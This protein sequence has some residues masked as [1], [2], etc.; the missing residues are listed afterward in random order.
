MINR[1]TLRGLLPALQQKV[2]RTHLEEAQAHYGNTRKELDEL[3]NDELGKSLI[4]PQHL[5]AVVDK[6]AAEDLPDYIPMPLL[7]LSAADPV[8][9]S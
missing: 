2:D 1:E 4:H 8:V 5:T 7:I 9:V 3:A 6:L